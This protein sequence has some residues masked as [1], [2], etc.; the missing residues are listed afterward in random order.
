MTGSHR[1]VKRVRSDDLF[2]TGDRSEQ[3]GSF[4]N[5]KLKSGKTF[6]SRGWPWTQACIRGVLGGSEKVERASMLADGSLL[7]KTKNQAQTEKLM[8]AS[9]FGDEECEV[10]RE[11]KMNQSR[12]TIHA[13]DLVDLTETE[14]VSWLGEFGV[15]GARRYTRKTNGVVENTPRVLLT[16]DKPT[17]P[18]KLELDYVTYHVHQYIPNPLQCYKCGK[19]GHTEMRCQKEKQCLRCGNKQHDGG[20]ESWCV[21]CKVPGHPCVDRECKEWKKE[22]EICRIKTEQ[23]ISYTQ[24]RQQYQKEHEQGNMQSNMRS[25]AAVTRTPSAMSKQ[26]DELKDKVEKLE[27]KLDEMITLMQKLI[28]KQTEQVNA[29]TDSSATPVG[30]QEKQSE[31]QKT[32]A[33]NRDT[34][35]GEQGMAEGIESGEDDE[36]TQV[37]VDSEINDGTQARGGGETNEVTQVDSEMNEMTHSMAKKDMRQTGN[38]AG[39]KEKHKNKIHYDT[40]DDDINPSPAITRAVSLDRGKRKCWK[41]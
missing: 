1:P 26:N 40:Q 39:R 14:I 33:E 34:E 29:H 35:M 36:V 18:T 6:K 4:L 24:A 22:K 19:L 10:T 30:S 31:V 13:Y 17:C 25:F 9:L 11:R 20:C 3:S 8:K 28:P 23:A 32:G 21:N 15:V 7:V 2:F 38:R 12:G 27:K 37:T 16:F 41:C 5:V